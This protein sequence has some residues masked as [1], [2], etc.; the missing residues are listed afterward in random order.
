MIGIKDVYEDLPKNGS[1]PERSL[2]DIVAIDI[3][4]ANIPSR[5]YRGFDSIKSI[6][7]YHINT[8][9]WHGIG[10]HYII[11]PEGVLWKT[12]LDRQK[13]WSV[14][15]HNGHTI[16][17]LFFGDFTQEDLKGEQLI[18]GVK[19]IRHKM[20]AYSV[21]LDRVKGHNE[22]EGHESNQCPVFDMEW[23]RGLLKD[24]SYG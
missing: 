17:T 7:N 19:W 2:G 16:S 23:F 10:Y 1:Y 13:R 6:A 5:N 21:P 4:H 12:G 14:G 8:H 22:Y 18:K 9:D 20:N 15:N 11:D 3:H 24:C